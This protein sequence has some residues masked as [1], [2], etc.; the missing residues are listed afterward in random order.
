M[1]IPVPCRIVIK[2]CTDDIGGVPQARHTTITEE[3]LKCNFTRALDQANDYIHCPAQIDQP[4]TRCFVFID[5]ESTNNAEL[6]PSQVP[7][8]CYRA[9][10]SDT[11][12]L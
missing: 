3:F 12:S 10:K 5:L 7:L 2:L 6:T 8:L 9:Q 4:N 11:D 1:A